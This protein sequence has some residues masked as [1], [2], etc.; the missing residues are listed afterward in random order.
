M[1]AGNDTSVT[2]MVH[3]HSP[4]Y[5]AHAVKYDEMYCTD[6][7]L[8]GV[9]EDVERDYI[10]VELLVLYGSLCGLGILFAVFCL[11]FNWSY[12]KKP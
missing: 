7:P 4:S 6:C 1:S 9:P 2:T 5:S 12:R 11:V 8:D 10:N 3:H